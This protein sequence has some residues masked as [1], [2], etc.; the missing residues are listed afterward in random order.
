MEMLIQNLNKYKTI[1]LCADVHNFNIALLNNNLGTV[2]SVQVAE[3]LDLEKRG[4]EFEFIK[5]T[6]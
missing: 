3:V 6:Q 5:I 4:R 2:I 1:Y